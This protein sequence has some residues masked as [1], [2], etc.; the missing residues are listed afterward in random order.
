MKKINLI[1]VLLSA[2]FITYAQEPI[3]S[4]NQNIDN[5]YK[6]SVGYNLSPLFGILLDGNEGE[7]YH[8]FLFKR[9]YKKYNLRLNAIYTSDDY[10]Y[11]YSNT[12]KNIVNI[13]DSSILIRN[14]ITVYNNSYQLNLGIERVKE[15]KKG[16]FFIGVD[17]FSAYYETDKTYD[18]NLYSKYAKDWASSVPCCVI[19]TTPFYFT[20]KDSF[21]YPN[22]KQPYY[23]SNNL[24]MGLSFILGYE[25]KLS[26][27]FNV[28]AS[29]NPELYTTFIIN[30]D[31]YD[32][33]GYYREKSESMAYDYKWGWINVYLSYRFNSK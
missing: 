14:V 11:G 7:F 13:T 27:R 21:L 29:I 15:T 26:K 25:W 31:F 10:N 17:I 28:I 19:D 32:E 1:F 33:S 8:S 24:K 18:Y 22:T 4:D 3:T 6:Y 20:R 9:Y 16:M 2:F 5:E 23:H 12:I 30:Q